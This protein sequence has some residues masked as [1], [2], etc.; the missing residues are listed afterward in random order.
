MTPKAN[1]PSGH[2]ASAEEEQNLLLLEEK[3][4]PSSTVAQLTDLALQA[5]AALSAALAA[6]LKAQ[7]ER[8]EAAETKTD[9]ECYLTAKAIGERLSISP[10]L[11][12]S[13]AREGKI[14]RYQFGPRYVRFKLSEVLEDREAMQ[15]PATGRQGRGSRKD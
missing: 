3:Y 2:R 9:S 8:Q 4:S 14:R 5:L 1:N 13:W 10:A 6:D 12:Q 7:E 11:L 15:G